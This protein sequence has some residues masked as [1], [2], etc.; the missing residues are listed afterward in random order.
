MLQKKEMQDMSTHR[1]TKK[2][3]R[4]RALAKAHQ[5]AP[6]ANQELSQLSAAIATLTDDLLEAEDI[7]SCLDSAAAVLAPE[8]E[9]CAEFN[10]ADPPAR[11]LPLALCRAGP[12]CW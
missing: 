11:A 9:S 3:K 7:F 6:K 8:P 1:R 2:N 10:F 4:E 5:H 12:P